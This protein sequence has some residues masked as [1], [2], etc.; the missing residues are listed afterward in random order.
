MAGSSEVLGGGVP[1]NSRKTRQHRGRGSAVV[2]PRRVWG[3]VATLLVV[4]AVA[5]SPSLNAGFL[6]WDD[7]SYVSHNKLLRN[8]QGLAA[9]WDPTAPAQDQFYPLVFTSYWLEYQ[10]WGADSLAYHATNVALHLINVALVALLVLQLGAT[11]EI[12]VAAAAVFAVHPVQVSSVAWVAER[13][14]TLSGTFYLAAFILYLRH[15]RTGGWGAYAACCGAF[16]AA[17]LSKTQTVTLPLSLLLAEGLLSDAAHLRRITRGAIAVRLAPLVV[18]GCLASLVTM[19]VEAQGL[20]TTWLPPPAE[21]PFI[22]ATAPWFYAAKFLFPINL[23]PVYPRWKVSPMDLT[24]WIGIVAWPVA[25]TLA[26]LQRRRIIPLIKWGCGHFLIVLLPV[27]GLVPFGFQQFSFVADHFMYLAVIGGGV[28]L[29]ACAHQIAGPALR[30]RAVVAVLGVALVSLYATMTYRQ[31]RH[32]HDTETFWRYVIAHNADC[33]PAYY[34]LGELYS[35]RRQW[36][37]ALQSFKRSTDVRADSPGAFSNYVLALRRV[38]GL[39]PALEACNAKL[40]QAPTFLP[41]YLE[42]GVL[43]EQMGQRDEALG[44]YDR[45]LRDEPNGSDWWRAAQRGRSRLQAQ[46]PH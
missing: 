13:K 30:R 33:F 20:P 15:R 36:E 32:W 3:Y 18:L 27:L 11:P 34:S 40:A 26:F 14:N 45:V 28:A 19:N 23:V 12:A 29:A 41:A 25:A 9:I 44:D 24:W 16:A 5:F 31:A 7:E 35:G 21:R 4:T 42:R 43:Y 8:S 46:A 37:Q 22:A 6:S 39:E 17:L 2:G 1:A 10:V 38:H